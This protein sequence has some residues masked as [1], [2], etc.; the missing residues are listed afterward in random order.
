M[1]KKK[2]DETDSGA[3]IEER[4][5]DTPESDRAAAAEDAARPIPS[6][7]ASRPVEVGKL[8]PP[9]SPDDGVPLRVF[10]T[11]CGK[12]ADQVAGFARH[13]SHEK[14]G[15]RSIADWRAEFQKFMDRPVR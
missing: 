10:L 7:E 13:A 8:P 11:V 5:P 2:R 6:R 12:K 9:V 3:P 14:L 15:P 4:N 1:S